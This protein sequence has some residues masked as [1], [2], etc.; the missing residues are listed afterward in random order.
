MDYP[1][2]GSTEI[3]GYVPTVLLKLPIHVDNFK[4]TDL[5]ICGDEMLA[6]VLTNLWI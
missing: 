5:V 4:V 2:I 6:K 3:T 1:A